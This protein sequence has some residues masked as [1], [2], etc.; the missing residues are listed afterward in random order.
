[1]INHRHGP[2]FLKNNYTEYVET[3][4]CVDY[5]GKNKN[6]DVVKYFYSE[7]VNNGDTCLLT[8]EVCIK[9]IDDVVDIN[10]FTDL[11]KLFR[12][13]SM[14]LRFVKNLKRSKQRKITFS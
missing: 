7:D 2:E 13:T 12:V 8:T 9:T 6:M 14:V 3:N 4:N 10:K 11:L 5:V 1:M